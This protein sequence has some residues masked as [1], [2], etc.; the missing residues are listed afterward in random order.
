MLRLT[1]PQVGSFGSKTTHWVPLR[2]DFSRKLNSRRTFRWRHAGSLDRV[3]APHTRMPRP[4]KARTQLMPRVELV[5]L[6]R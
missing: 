2:I 5:V 3:R 1:V 6:V 4:G